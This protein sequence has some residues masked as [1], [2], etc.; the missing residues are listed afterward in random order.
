[1]ATWNAPLP[2][3]N[4]SAGA[5]GH[6]AMH[7]KLVTAIQEVRANVDN[8]PAGAPGAKGDK[9]DKGDTGNTGAQ[10]IQGVK[11]DTGN[12]GA[13]GVQGLKGDKGDPGSPAPLW[14]RAYLPDPVSA[15]ALYSGTAPTVTF[16]Q[17]TTPT[18][19]YIR[20]S[21][22]PVTLSGTDVRAPFNFA[23]ASGFQVGASGADVNY[24]RPTS[25]YPNAWA[26]PQASWSVEFSTDTQVLQV[27]YQW[28]SAATMYRLSVDGRRVTDLMQSMGPHSP[29]PGSGNMMTVDFGS[30]APRRLRFDFSTC[31]FGGVY[32]PPATSMWRPNLAG[33]RLMVFGD[34][35]V[36]GSNMNTGGSSGT[37]ADRVA[38]RLG[39]TDLWRQGIGGTGYI[40][41]GTSVV[42]GDRATS[43]I[44]NLAPDRL[45]IWGG[46]NDNQGDQAALSTAA[47]SLFNTIKTGLPNCK[48]YVIGCWSP[49]GTATA[50][51]TNT[52]AT[53]KASAALANFYFISPVSG[54]VY[55]TDGSLIATQG[56]WLTTGQVA[57]YIGTDN[58]HPTDTGHIYLSW[59]I[60]S[61][62]AACMPA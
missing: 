32:L 31:P 2:P 58:V 28:S 37:W 10:G 20:Y 55:G 7:N 36:G 5:S 45:I 59:R 34:S 4:V 15:E 29:A 19:G 46:Y 3:D 13:Q 16:A 30:A 22:D 50:G 48:V 49:S 56:P 12:T 26:T 17:T 60:T 33:G 1:M 61:A 35:L 18:T 9:G 21:P 44:V 42:F 39:C 6:P 52:D 14:R 38:R 62:V 43:D 41:P 8:I 24:V 51:V 11:G 27:R 47:N 40:T 57:S 53:L 25:K 54:S 23:G